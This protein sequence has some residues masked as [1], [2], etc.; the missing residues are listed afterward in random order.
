MTTETWLP[1]VLGYLIPIGFFLLGWGGMEPKQ[2]RQAATQGL[3]ALAL[4]TLGYFAVGFAFHL[5]GAAVVSDQPGLAG[6]D[7]LVGHRVEAGL[8]WGIIGL[9][10]FFLA[11]DADT[12]EALILFATYLPMVAT[13]VLL[14]VLSL[15]NR[16]RGWHATLVGLLIAAVLFPLAAC[17]TWGGGWL[18]NLG[19]TI[20]RGHGLVDYAGS[21]VV[22]LLGGMVALGGLI[23]LGRKSVQEDPVQMPPTHFPL[24]ANLGTLLVALGWLGWSLG[25]PFHA[26]G[27]QIDAGRVAVNGLLALAGGTLACLLY[28]W[29]ALGHGDP[30]MVARGATAG[31][32]AISAGAPFLPPWSALVVGGVAGLLLP[33][34]I[35]LTDHVLRLADGT[36]AVATAAVSGLWGLLTVALLSD[37][38]W[39]QGW[40]SVGVEEYR[41]IIGQGVTG[42]RAA[43][44]FLGDGPGQSIAQVSGLVAIALLGLFAGWLTMKA[45]R[46]LSRSPQ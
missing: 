40:N 15:A 42:F 4:A 13:A 21:G 26:A 45:L 30:L 37:G 14:A 3:M 25:V 7:R 32:V 23:A 29:L 10:G 31:L 5:G 33:L 35:F 12:P 20:Y 2:A 11:G 6:L 24:L 1:L 46:V 8:Y 38:R 19:R 9:D 17:W 16:A 44:G 36:G 34:T 27:A 43:Q 18:A 39:G 41:T 28:C 22:Y